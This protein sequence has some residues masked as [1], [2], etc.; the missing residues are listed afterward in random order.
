METLLSG[1][2]DSSSLATLAT[3]GGSFSDFL[4]ILMAM[5]PSGDATS[6]LTMLSSSGILTGSGLD[7][8]IIIAQLN[9]GGTYDP[10]STGS[11]A[12]EDLSTA[13]GQVQ[14]GGGSNYATAASP[15]ASSLGQHLA[16]DVIKGLVKSVATYAMDKIKSHKQGNPP[17]MHCVSP[18]MQYTPTAPIIVI[19]QPASTPSFNPFHLPSFTQLR[20]SFGFG[21][22]QPVQQ[23]V[24][25]P[26][27]PM[28]PFPQSW[29]PTHPMPPWPQSGPGQW[30]QS[31][32]YAQCQ[33]Y[34]PPQGHAQ[35][36]SAP[37][38]GYASPQGCMTNGNQP[39]TSNQV[40]S[41]PMLSPG[42]ASHHASMTPGPTMQGPQHYAPPAGVPGQSRPA[43]GNGF[44]AR[45]G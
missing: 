35:Y 4:S 28:Q 20:Q 2:I 30:G 11:N 33:N 37:S 40:Q 6:F 18:P 14:T 44:Y 8:A 1:L 32:P 24:L 12:N 19:Q 34:A 5:S 41:G 45:S 3:S 22:S 13:Q 16:E 7:P 25:Q 26:S 38:Y 9:A 15:D 39:F 17:T 10:I 36:N 21:H 31:P 42:F 27:P 23:F 29:T 43:P